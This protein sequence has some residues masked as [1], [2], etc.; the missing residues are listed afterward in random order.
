MIKFILIVLFTFN[1]VACGLFSHSPETIKNVD[2]TIGKNVNPYNVN[3]AS[4]VILRIYQL[5]NGQLFN[6]APFIEL[7]NNDVKVLANELI[8]KKVLPIF[9]PNSRH[10]IALELEKE[11]RYVAVLAEFANFKE[12]KAKATVKLPLNEDFIID[13]KVGGLTVTIDTKE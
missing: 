1:L 8:S 11:A 4:P 2:I 3:R 9:K 7:Y 13:I 6:D 12:G 5:S 10:K